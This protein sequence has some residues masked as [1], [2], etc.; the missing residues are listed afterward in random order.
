MCIYIYIYIE[1]ERE[2][3]E[4]FLDI[5]NRSHKVYLCALLQT[6]SHRRVNW[7]P[8][9]PGVCPSGGLPAS[10]RG[11]PSRS[12]RSRAGGGSGSGSWAPRGGV[13]ICSLF[14]GDGKLMCCSPMGPYAS[15]HIFFLRSQLLTNRRPLS[16][17]GPQIFWPSWPSPKMTRLGEHLTRNTSLERT[18]DIQIATQTAS[19]ETHLSISRCIPTAAGR[20]EGTR[21]ATSAAAPASARASTASWTIATSCNDKHNN[22]NNNNNNNTY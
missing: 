15:N 19:I 16:G 22:D 13:E 7:G 11:T 4:L 1:R 8:G 18:S 5:H 17:S 14:Y 20:R 6:L 12:R 2:V 9:K 3:D 10:P 21:P